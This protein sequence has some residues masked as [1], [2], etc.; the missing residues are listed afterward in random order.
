MV[1]HGEGYEEA[2]QN[3]RQIGQSATPKGAK[4]EAPRK[5]KG[6]DPSHFF[7]SR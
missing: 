4:T 7:C 6:S 2:L 3:G 1:S 5:F